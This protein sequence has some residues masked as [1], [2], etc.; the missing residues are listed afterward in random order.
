MQNDEEK[1]L[2]KLSQNFVF[3]RFNEIIEKKSVPIGQTMSLALC[4]VASIHLSP[5]PS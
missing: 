2:F 5:K 1:K 4:S 3:F